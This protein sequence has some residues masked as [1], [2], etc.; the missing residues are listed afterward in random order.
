MKEKLFVGISQ[1]TPVWLN[2]KETIAKVCDQIEKGDLKPIRDMAKQH[3]MAIY[4]GTIE[5][6]ADRGNYSLYASLVFI[7]QDII[8][9]LMY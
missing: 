3:K 4:L 7:L 9:G 8:P 2:K 5:R 6:A 1:I